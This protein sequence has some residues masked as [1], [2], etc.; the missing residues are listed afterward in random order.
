MGSLVSLNPVF[1]P[2]PSDPFD[3]SAYTIP[4]SVNW[5]T[6]PTTSST[7]NV[8]TIGEFQDAVQESNV[9]INVAAGTYT[10]DLSF[11]GTDIDVVMSNSA[12]LFGDVYMDPGASGPRIERIR[13][14]G[15]NID[16]EG[17]ATPMRWTAVR[18]VLF[19]DIYI[20]GTIS[21]NRRTSLGQSS[22][23]VAIIN[24]TIDGREP[25]NSF[26]IFV[27]Q[28]ASVEYYSDLILANVLIYN[29]DNNP[30][31]IQQ[32]DRTIVV[33]SYF[34]GLW[35]S[36]SGTSGF[37]FGENCREAFVGGTDSKRTIIIGR[38]HLNHVPEVMPEDYAIIDSVWDGIDRYNTT[39]GGGQAFTQLSSNTGTVSNMDSYFTTGVGSPPGGISPFTTGDNVTNVQSWDGT[40]RP[41]TAAYGAQR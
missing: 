20:D 34:S 1:I 38:V 12:T 2:G 28:D 4:F 3:L 9:L 6:P 13:W 19:N 32:M 10:G 17:E 24:S 5:P 26:T 35:P 18:D 15:G 36:T 29:D 7:I 8:T 16:T 22:Q 23:R 37:R 11:S 39:D 27:Q 31:R 33:E 40:T 25:A 41:S 21:I 30:V 14:T